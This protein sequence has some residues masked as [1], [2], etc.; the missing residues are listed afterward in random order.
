MGERRSDDEEP[1]PFH[2]VE[3]LPADWSALELVHTPRLQNL[4]VSGPETGSTSFNGRKQRLRA[5]NPF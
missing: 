4:K 1:S 2:Y 3:A 5:S